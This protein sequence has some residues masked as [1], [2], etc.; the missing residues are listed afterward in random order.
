[1]ETDGW[2]E[3]CS[4][5]E[6]G[7]THQAVE[8]LFGSSNIFAKIPIFRIVVGHSHSLPGIYHGDNGDNL[9]ADHMGAQV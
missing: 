6:N 3:W 5:L 9:Y 2:T 7:D 4:L 1:M 8:K